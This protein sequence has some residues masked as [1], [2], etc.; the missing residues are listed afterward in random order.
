MNYFIVITLT[1]CLSGLYLLYN[2]VFASAMNGLL[3]FITPPTP[4]NEFRIL[5]SLAPILI[6][7]AINGCLLWDHRVGSRAWGITALITCGATASFA[8]FVCWDI[9]K[10]KL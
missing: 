5:W 7:L 4:I 1:G 10:S 3:S 6:A 2:L 9:L 8:S